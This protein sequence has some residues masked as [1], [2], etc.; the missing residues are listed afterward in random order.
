MKWLC[1]ISI[2][3]NIL[4]ILGIVVFLNI[5]R[6][7]P[8]TLG[9]MPD[10]F[11]FVVKI[12][13]NS[14]QINTYESILTKNLDWDKDTTISFHVTMDMKNEIFDYLKKIDIYKYPE[15]Y[16]PTSTLIALP[17]L[18]YYFEFTAEDQKTIINWEENTA[19][20]TRDARRLRKLF[21][22]IHDYIYQDE[23][24]KNLPETERLFL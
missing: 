10:D 7:S 8:V 2:L 17:S 5:E 24:V 11:D 6:K 16:A 15:N 9:N 13:S 21:H 18:T 4:L 1:K 12:N 22:K 23:R 19:S 3:L 20:E 14:Y